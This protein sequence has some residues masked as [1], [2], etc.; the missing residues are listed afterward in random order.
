MRTPNVGPGYQPQLTKTSTVA[1]EVF[2]SFHLLFI[3]TYP[4]IV[5]LGSVPDLCQ[6]SNLALPCNEINN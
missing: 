2:H 3:R 5:Q 4:A 1:E 6:R